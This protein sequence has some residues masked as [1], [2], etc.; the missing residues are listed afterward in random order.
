MPKR[1][2]DNEKQVQ[3]PVALGRVTVLSKLKKK[4]EKILDL[5]C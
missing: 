5:T 2:S 4:K 3:V 1:K